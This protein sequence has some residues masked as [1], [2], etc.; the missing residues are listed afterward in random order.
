MD[1]RT[2]ARGD[3]EQLGAVQ[4]EAK[5]SE[6][7]ATRET[8]GDYD[9]LGVSCGQAVALTHALLGDLMGIHS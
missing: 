4:G 2:D 9:E 6:D 3:A 5:G 8:E 7:S 1:S